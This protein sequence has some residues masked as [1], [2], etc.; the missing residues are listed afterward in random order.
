M[1][2]QFNVPTTQMFIFILLE[3]VGVLLLGVSFPAS[4]HKTDL[5][6][7]E[8]RTVQHYVCIKN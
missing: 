5:N 2:S 8:I 7:A 6:A 1:Y 3:S 4:I